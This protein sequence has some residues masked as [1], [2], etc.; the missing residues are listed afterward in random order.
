MAIDTSGDPLVITGDLLHHQLQLANPRIAEIADWDVE[1]ARETRSMFFSE[2][3]RA[4]SLVAG[5]LS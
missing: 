3:S 4:G 1:L 5:T 2:Q